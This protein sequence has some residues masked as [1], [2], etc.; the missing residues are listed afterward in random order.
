[1]QAASVV[2][3]AADTK[4]TAWERE[5]PQPKS[6]KGIRKWIKKAGKVHERLVRPS[7]LELLSAEQAFADAQIAFAKVKPA[8]ERD[9]IS[10]ACHAII[11]DEVSL[12]RRKPISRVV[13]YHPMRFR[14]LGLEA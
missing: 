4:A 1:M 6:R 9:L 14:I 5:H 13:A 7:W 10:M 2:Y 3:E 8:D 12:T 11:Y